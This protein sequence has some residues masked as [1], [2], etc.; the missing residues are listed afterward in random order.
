MID[1]RSESGWFRFKSEGT[2][3]LTIGNWVMCL[4]T[5]NRPR[6]YIVQAYC[7]GEMQEI[8]GVTP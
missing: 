7:A 6:R 4:V 1:W 2:V 8:D 3:Q 5:T